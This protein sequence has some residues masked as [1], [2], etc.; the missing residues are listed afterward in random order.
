[1]TDPRREEDDEALAAERTELAWGR[2]SLA[3]L[4]CGVAVARGFS[5][6]TGGDTKPVAGVVLLILGGLAWA[7]GLPYARAR[8]IGDERGDRHVATAQELF[9]LA[10]GTSLVGLAALVIELFLPR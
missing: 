7:I 4:V 5:E 8:A 6:A 10:L 9:P 3:L 2:S 1:V